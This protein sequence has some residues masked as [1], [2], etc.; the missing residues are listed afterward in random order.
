MTGPTT[1]LASYAVCAGDGMLLMVAVAAPSDGAV[2]W[3]LPGGG[4]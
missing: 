3:I 1:R 2:T 4:V